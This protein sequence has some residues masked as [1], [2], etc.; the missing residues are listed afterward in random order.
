MPAL[1]ILQAG[2]LVD[3]KITSGYPAISFIFLFI[4]KPVN[5]PWS[6]TGNQ[7]VNKPGQAQ[8]CYQ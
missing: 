3:L 5:R 2:P 7:E 6:I 8:E 1:Y 4:E